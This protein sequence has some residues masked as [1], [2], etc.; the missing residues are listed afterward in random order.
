MNKSK[1][2]VKDAQI[3]VAASQAVT[4]PGVSATAE[5]S[6]DPAASSSKRSAIPLRVVST[7]WLMSA[8][9]PPTEHVVQDMVGAGLSLLGGAPKTGK[10]AFAFQLADAVAAGHLF[11]GRRT[12]N[13]DVLY[14][15][16]EDTFARLRERMVMMGLEASEHLYVMTECPQ[17]DNGFATLIS[18]F[19]Q[20]HPDLVLVIVDTLQW[21]VQDSG[22]QLSYAR[23]VNTLRKLKALC[24]ELDVNILLIHHTNKNDFAKGIQRISGTSGLTGTAD[25]LLVL[26]RSLNSSNATLSFVGKDI[27]AGQLRLRMSDHLV[28]SVTDEKPDLRRLP[29]ELERFCVVVEEEG[30]YCGSNPS[31]AHWLEEHEC[32]SPSLRTAEGDVDVAK[33]RR[34]A[35]QYERE[36]AARGITIATDGRTA[37]TRSTRVTYTPSKE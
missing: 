20:M 23:D 31:F 10:S 34:M 17:L 8:V 4:P 14:I 12:L 1:M 27:S 26:E 5:T 19:K 33:F 25:T 15:A 9:F 7:A 32:V 22:R 30:G 3:N 36:L 6:I 11:L 21:L 28:F 29:K 37:S 18:D 24:L 16:M 2:R 13:G 35:R